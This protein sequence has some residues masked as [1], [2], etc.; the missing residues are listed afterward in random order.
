MKP[1]DKIRD[2]RLRGIVSYATES[3]PD[4]AHGLLWK[5]HQALAHELLSWRQDYVMR[6]ATADTRLAAAAERIADFLTGEDQTAVIARLVGALQ[7]IRTHVFADLP[8][9]TAPP[10]NRLQVIASIVENS[11]SDIEHADAVE[12]PR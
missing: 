1:V 2:E 5:E 4:T 12:A 11:L 7:K 9:E 3:A 10:R 8:V 6:T